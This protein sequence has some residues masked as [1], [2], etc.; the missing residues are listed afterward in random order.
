M[1]LILSSIIVFILSGCAAP[2][3]SSSSG[4]SVTVNAGHGNIPEALT[5][6]EAEC[7]K[8]GRH[9]RFN[10]AI[11]GSPQIVFDCVD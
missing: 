6:A 11:P 7:A 1:K 10:T 4:R 8:N 5:V 2:T 3:I 9:A